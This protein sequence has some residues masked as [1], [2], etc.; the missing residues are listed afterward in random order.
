MAQK[1]HGRITNYRTGIRE[2]TSN[3]CLIEFENVTS[4]SLASKLVGKKVTWKN[5]TAKL[6]G[7]IRGPHGKNGMVRV[8]F[9]RGVP[10][11]AIGSI[12][13]LTS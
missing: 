1:V 2:Q 10:G 11:Q 6:I 4:A 9:V 13:E 3:E 7:K 12:V 8:R 5:G